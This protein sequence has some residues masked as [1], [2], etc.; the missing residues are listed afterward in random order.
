MGTFGTIFDVGHAAG[1]I[2]TGL[3]LARM[4]YLPAF[5]IMAVVPLASIPIFLW[6][7]AHEGRLTPDM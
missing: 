5:W 6:I 3:L 4:G 7:V 2:I 1:P